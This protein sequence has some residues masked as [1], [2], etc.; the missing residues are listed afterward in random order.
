MDK[1]LE[2]VLANLQPG[3]RLE[4]KKSL[5]GAIEMIPLTAERTKKEIISQEFANLQGQPIS[6]SEATRKYGV[7]QPTLSRWIKSGHLSVLTN[8]GYRVLIDEAE[9]AY[10]AKIYHEKYREYAGNLKGVIIFDDQGNP[11]QMKYPDLAER[12]RIHRHKA[13]LD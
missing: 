5:T 4:I 8:D 10:C 2:K 12:K 11:Y 1:T 6:L 3:D 7:Q 13:K 9:A